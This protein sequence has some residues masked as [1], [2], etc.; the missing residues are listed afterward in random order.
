MPSTP[1]PL[2]YPGGK[3]TILPMISNIIQNNLLEKVHYVEPYAGGCG[4]ALSLLFNDY[5]DEIYLN[6]IDR[7]IWSFWNAVI[8]DTDRFISAIENIPITIEKWHIHKNIQKNSSKI[9]DFDLGFSTFILTEQID[10]V[11]F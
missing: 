11:L 3:T 8:N 1:S 4:L 9:S 5:V 2:R 6:D 7:S 10:L